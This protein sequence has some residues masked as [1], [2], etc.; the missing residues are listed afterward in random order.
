MLPVT[1]STHVFLVWRGKNMTFWRRMLGT[2]GS[3]VAILLGLSMSWS[4]AIPSLATAQAAASLCVLQIAADG[5]VLG[6]LTDKPK[7]F[8][9]VALVPKSTNTNVPVLCG[10]LSTLSLAVANQEAINV[11]VSALIFDN[12]GVALCTKGP[13]EVNVNGGVG[14]TFADCTGS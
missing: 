1:K 12:H 9:L 7:S 10:G 4:M 8:D 6:I 3:I 11:F 14:F 5:E 13:F 2:Q